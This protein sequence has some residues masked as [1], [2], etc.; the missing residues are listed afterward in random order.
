MEFLKRNMP[1]FLTGLAVLILFLVLIAFSQGNKTPTPELSTVDSKELI[2]DHTYTL[3]YPEAAFS[4]VMFSDLTSEEE[5]AYIDVMQNLYT[6]NSKYLLIALRHLPSDEEGI[7]T[8]KAAQ[9]AGE[10]GKFWEYVSALSVISNYD[11]Q[12]LKEMAGTL[13]LDI[14]RFERDFKEERFRSVVEADIEDAKSFNATKS[15]AFFLNKERLSVS[16]P[17]DLEAQVQERIDQVK[18]YGNEAVITPGEIEPPEGGESKEEEEEEEGITSLTKIELRKLN[19]V[20]EI[21]FT[22]EGWEP[23][24][25]YILKNQMVRWTN[26]TDVDIVIKQLNNVYPE[27]KEGII[28]KPGETFEFKPYRHGYWRYEEVNTGSWG[29]IFS[30]DY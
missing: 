3:G 12:A 24:E 2:A 29:S 26:N 1:I 27:F 7:Q 11:Y 4:L 14:Q 5:A 17:E 13:Q 30:Q 8:A 20:Q 9:I 21:G 19:S 22:S 28:I 6:K 23:R 16:S 15:P 18:I 25:A 10:Q